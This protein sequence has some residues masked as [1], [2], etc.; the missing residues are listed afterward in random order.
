MKEFISA[1]VSSKDVLKDCD[2]ELPD[3]FDSPHGSALRDALQIVG[4]RELKLQL[5]I[6]RKTAQQ[7]TEL[8]ENVGVEGNS[9]ADDAESKGRQFQKEQLAHEILPTVM[10]L[11]NKCE[12]KKSVF[13]PVVR[14]CVAEL[15]L[16]F[17]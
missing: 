9:A 2:L 15:L 12:K 17:K 7:L 5:G 14:N 3:S 8:N 4:C 1:W 10:S 16:D 11:K 6:I 13:L